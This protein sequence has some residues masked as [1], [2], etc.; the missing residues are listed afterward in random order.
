MPLW[1]F[2]DK[3]DGQV[4]RVLIPQSGRFGLARFPDVKHT[5]PHGIPEGHAPCLILGSS[6][7]S[8]D[9]VS[10]PNSAMAPQNKFRPGAVA[11]K[12][13]V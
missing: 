3:M 12:A 4:M 5:R 13:L 1:L 11:S 2:V 8:R 9:R 10:G 6:H 7:Q